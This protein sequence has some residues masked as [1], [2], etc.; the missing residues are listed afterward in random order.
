MK[1]TLATLRALFTRPAPKPSLHS[2]FKRMDAWVDEFEDFTF[3]LAELP[4]LNNEMRKYAEKSHYHLCS[5]RDEIQIE[6]RRTDLIPRRR[7]QHEE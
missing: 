7:T 6:L 4:G 1:K 2:A 3:L 5:L